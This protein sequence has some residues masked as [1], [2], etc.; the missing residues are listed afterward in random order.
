MK[1]MAHRPDSRT[2]DQWMADQLRNPM[3]WA[4][5]AIL[6]VAVWIIVVAILVGQE[7]Q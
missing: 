5:A 3:L 2:T 1:L 6:A 7:P 4:T